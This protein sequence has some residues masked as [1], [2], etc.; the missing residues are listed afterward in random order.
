[1]LVVEGGLLLR[2]PPV[3]TSVGGL[4][5]HQDVSEFLEFISVILKIS[6]PLMSGFGCPVLRGIPDKRD[7]DN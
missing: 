2:I 5:N 6:V 4:D 3:H 1:M 7:P